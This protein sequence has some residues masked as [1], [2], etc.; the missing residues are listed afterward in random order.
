MT[1]ICQKEQCNQKSFALI[2]F[3][4]LFCCIYTT[5]LQHYTA[6]PGCSTIS[7]LTFVRLIPIEEQRFG[8]LGQKTTGSSENLKIISQK[9]STLFLFLT[10]KISSKFSTDYLH[11][12]Q[13]TNHP[14]V[15][16][17]LSYILC[18]LPLLKL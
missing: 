1:I 8:F 17:L 15:N 9:K 11:P 4:F 14:H 13:M 6:F 5:G 18:F 2:L 16:I 7:K 12:P 3:T 10:L